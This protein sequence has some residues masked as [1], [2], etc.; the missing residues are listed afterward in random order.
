MR[1]CVDDDVARCRRVGLVVDEDFERGISPANRRARTAALATVVIAIALLTGA[2]VSDR[3][4]NIFLP[5]R[6]RAADHSRKR[7][8]LPVPSVRVAPKRVNV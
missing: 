5:H 3:A 4:T 2:T 7:I 6:D 1:N 8:H